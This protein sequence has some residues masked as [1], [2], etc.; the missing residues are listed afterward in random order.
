[1]N[2]YHH[3]HLEEKITKKVQ[4]RQKKKKP[5]MKISGAGVKQLQRIII[6]KSKS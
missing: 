2:N 5:K 3:E 1:M 6:K 4:R